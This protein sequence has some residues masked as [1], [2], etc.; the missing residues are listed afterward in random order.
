[1]KDQVIDL[2]EGVE[3]WSH[4]LDGRSEATIDG[5]FIKM[6]D[7]PAILAAHDF[8]QAK[9]R[10]SEAVATAQDRALIREA[11]RAEWAEARAE[12]AESAL[13]QA[14]QCAVGLEAKNKLSSVD[15]IPLRDALDSAR[16]DA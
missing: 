7:L 16:R 3:R 2:P 15:A 9:L 12:K 1:M 10:G 14:R 4:F 5:E 6:S 11:Q 13:E 8:E